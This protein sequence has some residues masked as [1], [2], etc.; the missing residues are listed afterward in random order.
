MARTRFRRATVTSKGQITLP[1]D[2]ARRRRLKPET[3]CA[4]CE[5]DGPIRAAAEAKHCERL[6][7]TE[8]SLRRAASI[9]RCAGHRERDLDKTIDESNTGLHG[10]AVEKPPE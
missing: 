10:D 8:A 1:D 9:A 5:G 3:D 4:S 2:F 7:E 6:D